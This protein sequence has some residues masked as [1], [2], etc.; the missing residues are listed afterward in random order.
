MRT[1][2]I[3]ELSGDLITTAAA[4]G[5]ILGITSMGGLVGVAVPLT[6][7]VVQRMANRDAADVQERARQADAELASGRPMSTLSDLLHE[8]SKGRGQEGPA[9][10]S[11]RELSGARLEEAS[12]NGEALIVSS[13]RVSVALL[14]PVT[15]A[16]LERLVEDGVKRFIDGAAPRADL[17]PAEPESYFP[18]YAPIPSIEP[19]A[20]P[21]VGMVT[22]T[23]EVP[24]Q[25]ISTGR[26]IN[27]Q[28]AIGIRILADAPDDRSRLLGV[29]TDMLGRVIGE[30]IQHQ[31]PNMDEGEVFE[32][33]LALI[34]DLHRY[35]SG[36][37][38]LIGVGLEIG[39]HVHDSRVVYSAN[40]H[41][42][43]FP[44]ADR[45]NSVLGLPVVLENDAN[46]L[47][48]L[49][50]RFDGVPDDNLA[51]ILV[52][53]QGV[54]SGLVID[55]RI[56]RGSSGMAGEIGHIPSA[57]CDHHELVCRCGHY[58]CLE[59]M[60]TPH[61]IAG[62]L[63]QEGFEGDY[64]AAL[65]QLTNPMVA[66]TLEHAGAALGRA[67]AT[68]INLLN[69]STIVFYGPPELFGN[70][71]EFRIGTDPR[72]E[73]ASHPYLAAMVEATRDHAFSTGASSCR[74][75]VRT[76]SD[77]I[78]ARAAAACII[79][80]VHPTSQVLRGRPVMVRASAR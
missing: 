10:I 57:D 29:V 39:G 3:R 9:R 20:V 72:G 14:I 68:V 59:A 6:R 15:Q 13:D 46:A 64:T 54:G 22:P 37:Q 55:G 43:D 24:P 63:R 70:S 7:E 79:N 71:R 42:G 50:R 75:I 35:I 38:R 27:L 17:L 77:R 78:S 31:L 49:E 80:R 4:R 41:W 52:T 61:A 30:P 33:T 25:Q 51:V 2:A 69:P 26:E 60:A 1:V 67:T 12:R 18:D 28:R 34:D 73:T 47:A 62:A 16:W 53:D 11:I 5:Q 21:A 76:A 32:S 66:K 45:L 48:V 40:A 74:F 65:N 44:L 58:D 36:Q 8:R 23:R 19:T 56:F